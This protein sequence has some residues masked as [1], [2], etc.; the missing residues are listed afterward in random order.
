VGEELYYWGI[1]A[2]ERGYNALFVDS[3]G[4]GL[5]PFNGIDFRTDTEVPINAAIDY[6]LSRIDVDT[7]RIVIY[8]GGENG[9]YI[10]TRAATHANHVAAL[11]PLISDMEPIAPLFLQ[12]VF[13][14][15]NNEE[16]LGSIYADLLA[17][18]C[19]ISNDPAK[20]D[21]IKKM[22]AD[23]SLITCPMLCLTDSTDYPEVHQQTD[24]A[25]AATPNTTVHNFTSADRTEGYRELD[26]F[27][28]KH[29]VMFDW[30]DEVFGFQG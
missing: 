14:A 4:I 2:I 3:P 7:S 13:H 10:M 22:K 28:L 21:A 8:G 23:V 1:P 15:S 29:R 25:V 27:S 20:T 11:D 16:S 5:N 9:G 26:N 19:S 12:N 24:E 17:L 30:L 6:L 18:T